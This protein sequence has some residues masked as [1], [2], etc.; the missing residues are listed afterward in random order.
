[1]ARKI[2]IGVGD[3]AH[4][5]KRAY[6]GDSNGKARRIKKVYL[7]VNGVAKLVTEMKNFTASFNANGGSGSMSTVSTETRFYTPGEGFSCTLPNNSFTRSG[8]M[9]KYW[10]T[11][12]DGSGTKYAPGATVTIYNDTTF[13]AQWVKLVTVYWYKTIN[14]NEAASWITDTAT[15]TGPVGGGPNNGYYLGTDISVSYASGEPQYWSK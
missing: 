14:I 12:A 13:Y 6:I 9:F 7:G 10:C 4:R 8:Y 11:T 1:M 5:V 3:V 15:A 2:Y